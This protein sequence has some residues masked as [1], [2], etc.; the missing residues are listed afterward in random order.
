VWEHG[1]IGSAIKGT[2]IPL[3]HLDWTSLTSK[4]NLRRTSFE[5]SRSLM[6]DGT[7]EKLHCHS[8]DFFT[9]DGSS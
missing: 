3:E 7:T 5:Y 6:Q 4:D 8:L 1:T 9:V 2:L